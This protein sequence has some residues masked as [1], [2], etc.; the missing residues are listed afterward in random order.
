MLE[1]GL[2]TIFR[3][4]PEL[5]SLAT[6]VD[7]RGDRCS[8]A[9]PSNV[10]SS[11]IIQQ[12]HRSTIPL[13]PNPATEPPSLRVVTQNASVTTASSSDMPSSRWFGNARSTIGFP[14][15]KALFATPIL[16]RQSTRVVARLGLQ[17]SCYLDMTIS[18]LGF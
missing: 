18:P 3:R 5:R 9:Q 10:E 15:P 4:T 13:L 16:K 6:R 7:R 11:V 2:R 12:V 1:S 8:C 14:G 17:A